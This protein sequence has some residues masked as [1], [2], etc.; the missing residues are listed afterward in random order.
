MSKKLEDLEIYRKK[1]EDIK[2][3]YECAVASEKLLI[4]KAK[5]YDMKRA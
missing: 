2:I 1:Y 3:M 5:V 4:K